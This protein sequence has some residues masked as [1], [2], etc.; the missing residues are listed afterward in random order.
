MLALA[1]PF[2]LSLSDLLSPK[3]VQD[4]VAR[5]P[6]IDLME[7]A[8]QGH[9][10]LLADKPTMDRIVAFCSRCDHAETSAS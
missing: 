6:D 3:G 1:L 4:M 7:V 8:D 10:P 5:R 9:A 2:L